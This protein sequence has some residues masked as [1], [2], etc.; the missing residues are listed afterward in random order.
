MVG[1]RCARCRYFGFGRDG[2]NGQARFSASWM[3]EWPR[4]GLWFCAGK[5][6]GHRLVFTHPANGLNDDRLP[7]MHTPNTAPQPCAHPRRREPRLP[8]G[9]R[10]TKPKGVFVCA[11]LCVLG[12]R[13]GKARSWIWLCRSLTALVLVSVWRRHAALCEFAFGDHTFRSRWFA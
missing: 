1:W 4:H 5:G 7:D 3:R 13:M 10:N 12:V 8:A 9:A 2:P 11:L 6:A